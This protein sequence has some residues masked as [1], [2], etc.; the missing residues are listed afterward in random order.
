VASRLRRERAQTEP[1]PIGF[2]ALWRNKRSEYHASPREEFET[3]R[4]IQSAFDAAQASGIR[5][6]GRFGCRWSSEWQYFTFW[7]SPSVGAVERTMDL[8]EA[9]GDFMFADS[10]HVL[11]VRVVEQDLP[12]APPRDKKRPFGFAALWRLTDAGRRHPVEFDRA[13]HLIRDIFAS[14][15]EAGIE[16]LGHFDCRWSSRWDA[17]TFWR[18]PTAEAVESMMGR[19]EEAGDFWFA[20]SMHLLGTSEPS[21]RF[22]RHRQEG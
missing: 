2:L 5:A 4:R 11:G 14:G 19:L 1:L 6:F 13:D 12:E 8:L 17:M 10:E 3:T 9:A 21:F 20:E 16:M 18:S 15:R 7:R 22:G